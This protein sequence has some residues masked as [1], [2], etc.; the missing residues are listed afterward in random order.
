MLVIIVCRCFFLNLPP[1][2]G[3][4]FVMLRLSPACCRSNVLGVSFC[5]SLW[6]CGLMIWELSACF[7]GLWLG[8]LMWLSL[9]RYLPCFSKIIWTNLFFLINKR[10]KPF[11]FVS[12]YYHWFF[13]H[14]SPFCTGKD[15]IRDTEKMVE[16]VCSIS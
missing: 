2:Y 10:G 9:Q 12:K 4:T 6:S 11:V 3:G 15:K 8:C 5:L 7:L 14:S 1:V 16:L 13:Q